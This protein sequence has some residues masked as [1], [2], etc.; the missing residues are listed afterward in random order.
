M[1]V[2]AAPQQPKPLQL[3]IKLT[4]CYF[5]NILLDVGF[6][7][8]RN[9]K[10]RYKVDDK[11]AN[12]HENSGKQQKEQRRPRCFLLGRAVQTP[13]FLPRTKWLSL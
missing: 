7:R 1:P 11:T 13:G 8:L 2:D 10:S 5:S 9:L 6:D 4:K 3:V 12:S